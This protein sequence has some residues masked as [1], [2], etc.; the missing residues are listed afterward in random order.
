MA[1]GVSAGRRVQTEVRGG[2]IG[3]IELQTGLTVS[4]LIVIGFA[5]GGWILARVLGG[6]TIFLLSYA[7]LFLL[8]VSVYIARR[9]RPVQ[10][11][12]AEPAC[13]AREGQ[14]LDVDLIF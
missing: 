11:E 8:G 12:R 3:A 1:A 2:L 14:I 13:R 9:K 6:R 7:A 5:L 4:G 10:A